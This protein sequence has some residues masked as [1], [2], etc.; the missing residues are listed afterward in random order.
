[1]PFLATIWGMQ[2]VACY[3]IASLT[4]TIVLGQHT[5]LLS[6]KA[7]S[8]EEFSDPPHLISIRLFKEVNQ[9]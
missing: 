8:L 2:P 7:K 6:D 4:G 5:K 1:M 3:S 9:D